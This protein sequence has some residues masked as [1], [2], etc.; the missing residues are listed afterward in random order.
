[1]PATCA[2]ACRDPRYWLVTGAEAQQ[3]HGL[4]DAEVA[5]LPAFTHRNG[6]RL[7]LRT[8]GAWLR[9]RARLPRKASSKEPLR[10]R[11][12]PALSSPSAIAASFAQAADAL[13]C[14]LET[15]CVPWFLQC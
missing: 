3:H 5:A 13:A 9:G 14:V 1:M 8:A 15:L 11:C 2:C 6:T 4:D 12:S 7:Y 10:C